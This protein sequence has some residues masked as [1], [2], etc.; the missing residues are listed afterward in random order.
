MATKTKIKKITISAGSDIFQSI[1][2][3]CD[4]LGAA[5]YNLVSSFVIDDSVVLIFQ[6]LI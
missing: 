4:T 1:Q 2:E 5:G 6:K 3:E